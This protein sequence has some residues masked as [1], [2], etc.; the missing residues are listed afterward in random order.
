[1]K[2]FSVRLF[3]LFV[4]TI[5]IYSNFCR[6]ARADV[7]GE[8]YIDVV[9]DASNCVDSKFSI[10][11]TELTEDTEFKFYMSASGT[12]YVDWGDGT[13][14]TIVRTDTVRTLYSHTYLTSGMKTIRFG[15][16]ATGYNDGYHVAA[17][18]FSSSGGF[19]AEI[20][21]SLG[22]IFS[23]LGS[24]LDKQPQFSNTFGGAKNLAT[25]PEN[26]FAGVTGA[27]E[28]MFYS[29]FYNSGITSI[30]ENL[31]SGI[32]GGARALFDGT[33]QRCESL[34]DIPERL[35]SNITIGYANMFYATFSFCRALRGI[36]QNLFGH[37]IKTTYE[38]DVFYAVFA[39]C[40]NLSGFIPPSLFAGLNN[41]GQYIRDIMEDIFTGT[42]L[43][44]T[45]PAG[46][47]QFVTGYE[48][49]WNGK[50]SCV[51]ENLV[52]GAGEYFVAHD[53]KC[54]KCPLNSYCPG[55]VYQYSETVSAGAISCPN[56]LYSP[57]GMSSS[58]Q[59]GRILHVGENVVYLH[60]VKKTSPALHIDMD[61]DGIADFF[62]NMTTLDVPMNSA[63]ERKLKI[64]YNG[65]TY[66]VY[67]DTIDIGE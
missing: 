62:G 37:I 23:T 11:T 40:T 57:A 15:G 12:F 45:C 56:N 67:D 18:N 61:N 33:F 16:L 10:T 14:D 64:N 66:S 3:R 1:M 21:G 9:G 60:S 24:G 17:V 34:R 53:Y 51:D 46:T 28:S 44:T 38:A 50:V 5:C 31:F 59:C 30:P 65:Q 8:N 29:T 35:F 54:S 2:K 22:S 42:N 13:V 32:Y 43:V 47:V 25:I 48:D 4:Y 6:I 49:Y 52:C 19:I 7:C 58:N 39:N 63:T 20:N 55:G 27:R 41:T 26:L 36:P